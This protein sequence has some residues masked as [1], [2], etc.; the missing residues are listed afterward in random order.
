MS[1]RQSPRVN[2][3]GR[4]L[5]T[6]RPYAGGYAQHGYAGASTAQPMQPTGRPMQPPNGACPPAFPPG[7][8][9]TNPNQGVFA[10]QGGLCDY[11]EPVCGANALGFNTLND[12]ANGIPAGTA[13]AQLSIDSGDAC[14]FMARALFLVAYEADA[15]TAGRV[16]SPL[17]QLPI[18][19]VNVRVGTQP[20][21][22]RIDQLQF[23]IISDG[24]SDRKEITPVD[25]KPF[26]STQNQGLI[27][28]F[29]SITNEP[30]HAFGIL[31]GDVVT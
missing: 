15:V 22:R 26:T 8:G 23:G 20:Q 18:L 6:P 10:C 14:K 12:F 11:A 27:I 29:A 13:S 5:A 9:P 31:W 25:W 7:C 30:V 17:V 16:A 19:I 1:R 2:W 24:F 4:G 28:A 3:A 21:I